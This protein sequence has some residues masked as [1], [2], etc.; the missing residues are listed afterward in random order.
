MRLTNADVDQW[1]N[2]LAMSIPDGCPADN[3]LIRRVSS[4]ID[5]LA[6]EAGNPGYVYEAAEA[7]FPREDAVP[8]VH[9]DRRSWT[10]LTGDQTV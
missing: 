10:V 2:E 5:A 7:V 6:I 4:M 3:V 1:L 9:F 8:V